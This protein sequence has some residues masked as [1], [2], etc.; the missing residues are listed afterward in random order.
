MPTHTVHNGERGSG[1]THW[2]AA[3][4]DRRRGHYERRQRGRV[5]VVMTGGGRYV[6]RM[7]L[8]G[9]VV[10]GRVLSSHHHEAGGAG[11]VSSAARVRGVG[12]KE[13]GVVRNPGRCL[14][15]FMWLFIPKSTRIQYMNFVQCT[16]YSTLYTVYRGLLQFFKYQHKGQNHIFYQIFQYKDVFFPQYKKFRHHTFV[17][18]K[19]T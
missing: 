16:V 9:V 11:T 8:D 6:V 1:L 14:D 4:A 12:V 19:T 18:F 3:D 13:A 17:R 5:M 15:K 10:G 7:Q 2:R